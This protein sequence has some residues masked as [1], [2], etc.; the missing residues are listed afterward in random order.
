[1]QCDYF[2][3]SIIM[4]IDLKYFDMYFDNI[5][6]DLL[7]HFLHNSTKITI[8]STSKD[9]IT[10]YYNIIR[11]LG[12]NSGIQGQIGSVIR[13]LTRNASFLF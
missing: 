12:D 1:M 11:S 3:R 6:N 8:F 2:D 13:N 9:I 7:L 4:I 10:V 5:S